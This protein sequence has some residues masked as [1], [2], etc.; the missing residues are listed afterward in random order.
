M[1]RRLGDACIR[2]PAWTAVLLALVF[3][4]Q[5]GLAIR[6]QSQTFDESVHLFSG[7]QYWQHRDFGANPE[8]PPLLKLL[9]ASPLLFASLE[10][11]APV[12]GAT[13]AANGASG[14]T[15]LYRNA[16]PA[17]TL[18]FSGRLTASLVGCLL[19][20]VVYAAG[21]EMFD[22]ATGLVAAVLLAFEP[23]LLANAP[24]ITTDVAV[25]TGLCAT[26]LAYV[27]YATRPTLGRLLLC[28]GCAALTF[29]SKHSAVLLAGI[30]PLVALG[31]AWLFLPTDRPGGAWLSRVMRAMLAVAAIFLMAWGGLWAVY[32]FRYAARPDGFALSPSLAAY[33]QTLTSRLQR[34]FIVAAARWHLLPEAYLW[35]LTDVFVATDGRPTFLLGQVYAKGQWFYFPLVFLMKSTL[36][37][38]VLLVGAPVV[39]WRSRQSAERLPPSSRV[40]RAAWFIVVPCV[41]W[42][43]VSMTSG[44]NIGYRHILPVLPFVIL[45]AAATA[46][47]LARHSQAGRWA[48]GALLVAH[49]ASSAQAFPN[50]LTYS[51]E[52]TG[53]PTRTY[54]VMTDSNSDWG[55]GM[56]QLSSYLAARGIR[57]CWFVNRMPHVDPNDL[58]VPCRVLQAGIRSRVAPAHPG[59]IEGTLVVNTNEINGQAWGPGVLNPYGFLA[60]RTPDALIANSIAVFSG[61]FDLSLAAASNRARRAQQLLTDKG[62]DE[63]VAQAREAVSLAPQSAEMHAVMCLAL[64]ATEQRAAAEPYC[65]EALAIA[66]RVEPEFQH[67]RVPA[68]RSVAAMRRR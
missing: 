41:V 24:L 21:R 45:M 35:G 40:A 25:T 12:V 5:A 43:G 55:Q 10:E 38:L 31:D 67:L 59:V 3:L 15:F 36:P 60:N 52:V 62:V 56:A 32:T 53:G 11:T 18:L 7:Y 61:R 6:Q 57:D 20:A 14:V 65:A 16:R 1:I 49:I 64:T 26:M 27:R 42:L 63:A 17:A 68:V 9:A 48:V 29:A 23:N 34:E 51:N 28:G 8:H 54:R 50:Y 19:I 33:A 46:V 22:I 30:L 13:K 44:L 2:R 4:V 37:M 66:D 47:T 58:G 39:F